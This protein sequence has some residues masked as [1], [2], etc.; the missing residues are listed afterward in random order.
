MGELVG[1]PSMNEQQS[2]NHCWSFVIYLFSSPTFMLP[3]TLPD[4]PLNSRHVDSFT[5]CYHPALRPDI[6]EAVS[7]KRLYLPGQTQNQYPPT[8][9][10]H[11]GGSADL[12]LA[13]ALQW[14]QSWNASQE[15]IV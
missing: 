1:F 12:T 4:F 11:T 15:I 9:T 6:S 13:R 7:S 3:I 14:L 5:S 2:E 10:L 8:Q